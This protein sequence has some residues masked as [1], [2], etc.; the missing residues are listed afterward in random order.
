[1]L[2]TS[3]GFE[4]FLGDVDLEFLEEL[5]KLNPLSDEILKTSVKS[6]L[7][8]EDNRICIKCEDSKFYGR[9]NSLSTLDGIIEK[10]SCEMNLESAIAVSRSSVFKSVDFLSAMSTDTLS[11][12]IQF[13]DFDGMYK[14]TIDRISDS[15]VNVALE[16]IVERENHGW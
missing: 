2:R 1:M 7:K 9:L 13:C 12:E 5:R 15:S 3:E 4:S 6:E 16:I 8:G 11:S 10:L 14:V